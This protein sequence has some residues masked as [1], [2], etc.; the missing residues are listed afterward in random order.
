MFRWRR[1][2]RFG[3]P[4]PPSFPAGEFW[5][6]LHTKGFLQ[7]S[8]N[9]PEN[10]MISMASLLCWLGLGC[11]SCMLQP[12]RPALTGLGRPTIYSLKLVYSLPD[13]A[14]NERAKSSL[15]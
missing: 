11:D 5:T 8:D 1:E 2:E 12:R 9:I 14:T 4:Y 10:P 6:I 15:P 13:R 7:I 3:K